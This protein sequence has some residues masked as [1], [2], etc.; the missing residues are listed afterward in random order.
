[1]SHSWPTKDEVIEMHNVT[2]PH[3]YCQS[4]WSHV[5]NSVSVSHLLPKLISILRSGGCFGMEFVISQP[6]PRELVTVK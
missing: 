3:L 1:M 6:F 5:I 4:R 2:L